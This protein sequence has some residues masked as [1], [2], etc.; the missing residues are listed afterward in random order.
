[1]KRSIS[2]TTSLFVFMRCFS[3][4]PDTDLWLFKI[5]TDKNKKSVLTHS[6]NITNR[7]GYDNQ[8]S[9]SPDG[10][11]LFYVSI[12]DDKQSDIFCYVVKSKKILR[13]TNTKESEYSPV[14]SNDGKY[15]NSVVVEADS[16]QRI[17]FID[18]KT[19]LHEKK[20][21]T[22]SVGYY[23]FL[24][25]DTVIFYKLTQPHSLR[26]IKGKSEEE[27]WLGNSPVRTFRAINRYTLLYGLKD[28]SKVT[29][30]TYNFLLHK[31]EKYCEYSSLNEDVVW[32]NELG[33]IKSEV[34][35]LMHYDE[36][37]KEWIVLYD[38]APFGVKK[39]TRF[40]FD[41]KNK[42]LVVVNNL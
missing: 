20:I 2:L 4:V 13:V 33:L 21:E 24:N 12:G 5:E 34:T 6:A 3:Q 35:K 1:M 18:A 31:A 29:F 37:K 40:A 11:K 15:L 25:K 22:D 36:L 23:T 32:H 8:P 39:I 41:P 26:Y 17:H 38:L 9:F 7:S 27:H 10:K 42:Y 19:G 28:S 16:A 14:I 30:Y